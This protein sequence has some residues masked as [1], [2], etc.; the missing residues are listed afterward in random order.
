QIAI[1]KAGK[2]WLENNE[3]S[4]GYLKRT[5]T[6]RQKKGYATKFF[7]PTTGAECSNPASMTDAASDFYESLFRAEPVN[8][9][10]INTMLSAIS[11]K[12][13][14][15]EADDLL[16]DITFDDIIKGAKRSPKQSSP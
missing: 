5:A 12:L 3:K 15:E 8:S 16:A 14:K 2:R 4:A 7:H 9:D 13:P 6:T 1:L 11:N 10:S